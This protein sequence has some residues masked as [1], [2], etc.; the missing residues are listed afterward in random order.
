MNKFKPGDLVTFNLEQL[1]E[2][3]IENAENVEISTEPLSDIFKHLKFTVEWSESSLVTSWHYDPNVR[4][5][6]T[7]EK[8]KLVG[9][10]QWF[11][12]KELVKV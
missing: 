5:Q 9:I 2:S 8:V 3:C 10:D 6:R 4:Q 1:L 7:V 11:Y 12:N